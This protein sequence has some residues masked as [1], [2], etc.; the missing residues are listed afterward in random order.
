MPWLRTAGT[1]RRLTSKAS[2]SDGVELPVLDAL[3][4]GLPLLPAE[5]QLRA[6]QR[7]FGV[8]HGNRTAGLLPDFDT[9]A[10]TAVTADP[11]VDHDAGGPFAQWGVCRAR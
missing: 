8:T 3:D 10:K 6:A 2:A 5:H 11:V 1:A 7:I 4:K 9:V